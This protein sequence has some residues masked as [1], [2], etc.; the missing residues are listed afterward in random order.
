MLLRQNDNPRCEEVESNHF[1]SIMV[2]L[3]KLNNTSI[4]EG[5]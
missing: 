2:F 5:S 3:A 1:L 4:I